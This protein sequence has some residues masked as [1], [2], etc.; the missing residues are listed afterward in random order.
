MMIALQ[1]RSLAPQLVIQSRDPGGNFI[2]HHS[3]PDGRAVVH[4]IGPAGPQGM[5]GADG[6]MGPQGLTGLAGLP[7]PQGTTGA[8]GIQ[9]NPG[10]IGPTGTT[11]PQGVPGPAGPAGISPKIKYSLPFGGRWALNLDQRWMG[12]NTLGPTVI[13]FAA[14]TATEPTLLWNQLGPLV[15]NG[16]VMKRICFAG[17]IDHPEISAINFRL[18][19]QSGQW[20]GTWDS[21]AETVRTL[22]LSANNVNFADSDFKTHQ[23]AINQT[24]VGDGFLVM[25][26]QPASAPTAVRN[27]AISGTVEWEPSVF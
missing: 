9:G 16:D 7:G 15:K 18:Y 24:L 12:F 6:P 19:H 3:A 17:L 5:I 14:G 10:P 8:P 27:L 21:P 25:F 11:G 22:L 13:P 20:T 2:L 1:W 4:L 26:V 23:F